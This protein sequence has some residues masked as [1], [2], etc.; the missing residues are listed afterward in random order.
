M[1]IDDQEF[2]LLL[3]FL[4]EDKVDLFGGYSNGRFMIFGFGI[5]R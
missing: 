3:D 4:M 2:F 5:L 1:G